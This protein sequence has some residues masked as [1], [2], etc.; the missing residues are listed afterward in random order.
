MQSRHL[1]S[2]L[3]GLTLPA[4]G[5]E[6]KHVSEGLFRT[7]V[8]CLARGEDQGVGLAPV[9]LPRNLHLNYYYFFASL[10]A[11]SSS[12]CCLCCWSSHKTHCLRRV[13]RSLDLE[14]EADPSTRGCWNTSPMLCCW[15][16]TVPSCSLPFFSGM[17][18]PPV[19]VGLLR[20]P[21]H[22]AKLV[23]LLFFVSYFCVTWIITYQ[24]APLPCEINMVKL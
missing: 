18:M 17:D 9:R 3:V 8:P 13:E 11:A 12:P 10:P 6:L 20:R 19:T 21:W 15:L 24:R 5:T 1:C 23:W 14:T 16:K 4:S 2:R 7:W 22:K